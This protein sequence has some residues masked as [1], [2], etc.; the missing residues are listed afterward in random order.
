MALK[1]LAACLTT[2]DIIE[3]A[4]KS[5]GIAKPNSK[6]TDDEIRQ[7]VRLIAQG[8]PDTTWE[9]GKV[10]FGL[11]GIGLMLFLTLSE[12]PEFYMRYGLSQFN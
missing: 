11:I 5:C 7:V 12:F 8:T 3:Q 2:S 9:C 1:S 4:K 10:K 6:M